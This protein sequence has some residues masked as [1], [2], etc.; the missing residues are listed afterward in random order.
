MKVYGS[1]FENLSKQRDGNFDLRNPIE[2]GQNSIGT[3]SCFDE[4]FRKFCK[5]ARF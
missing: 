3:H 4:N 5:K 2:P 1:S